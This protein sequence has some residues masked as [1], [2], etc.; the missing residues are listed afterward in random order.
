[1]MDK[2]ILETDRINHKMMKTGGMMHSDPNSAL[3][4]PGKSATLIWK[5]KKTKLAEFASNVPRHYESGMNG[6]IN[7]QVVMG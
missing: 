5:F 2:G 7:F 1:M 6:K 4:E 3:L